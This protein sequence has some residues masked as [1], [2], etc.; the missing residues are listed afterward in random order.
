MKAG[1]MFSLLLIGILLATGTIKAAEDKGAGSIVLKG[2]SI[3]SVT[4]PHGRHQGIFVDCTPC[5][6]LFG[7][8]SQVI[9]RMKSEGKLQKKEV[10]NL[11]K[12]CHKDLAAK[13]Q[14]AGP[15]ACKGCHEK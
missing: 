5:H 9:D 7:K 12:N 4:F 11:C 13:G 6:E 8:E 1:I 15:T 3:G 14:K 10:M 2:G